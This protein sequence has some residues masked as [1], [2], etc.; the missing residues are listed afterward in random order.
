MNMYVRYLNGRRAFTLVELLVVIA[1]IG[2]LIGMLLPAVQQV[3]EAARR[4]ECS[5]KIRQL[6]L[7]CHNYHSAHGNFPP[8]VATD[9]VV[10]FSTP[11][12]LEQ[13]LDGHR[14][15][16]WSVT[17]LPFIEQNNAFDNLDLSEEFSRHLRAGLATDAVNYLPGRIPME[18][19]M[20]PS[21][22]GELSLGEDDPNTGDL[23]YFEGCESS[24]SH[25][26]TAAWPVYR[27][28]AA[29]N[30]RSAAVDSA[31]QAACTNAVNAASVPAN[32][33]RRRDQ[34]RQRCTEQ[35]RQT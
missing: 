26:R 18:S 3:R 27:V 10:D 25:R 11:N 28:Y 19:F 20:C 1:I 9:R 29:R 35:S 14:G 16:P 21:I 24:E 15:A 30:R 34:G 6:A 32:R 8:G 13:S 31:R 5:N 7:A 33:R 22:F 23:A 2:I 4:T 17:I 12:S